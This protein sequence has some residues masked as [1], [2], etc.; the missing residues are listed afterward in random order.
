MTVPGSQ[1]HISSCSRHRQYAY[2]RDRNTPPVRPCRWLL[3]K[4][5]P[6]RRTK[7][8]GWRT[9]WNMTPN[10]IVEDEQRNTI[11][12]AKKFECAHGAVQA[13]QAS[14][15]HVQCTLH[16]TRVYRRV[17]WIISMHRYTEE[18]R[19]DSSVATVPCDMGSQ[20]KV[21]G[22]RSPYLDISSIGTSH[23]KL[24]LHAM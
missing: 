6:A 17:S 20:H 11:E 18:C 2:R 8:L 16:E 14:D 22:Q 12:S 9:G 19:G 15:M 5:V 21:R 24:A 13:G 4:R 7:A 1:V 10:D 3:A 23:P